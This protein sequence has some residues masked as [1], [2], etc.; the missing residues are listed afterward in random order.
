M[1]YKLRLTDVAL[2]DIQKH[3]KSGDKKIL[4]LNFKKTLRN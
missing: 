4:N 3:K 2:K 1:S